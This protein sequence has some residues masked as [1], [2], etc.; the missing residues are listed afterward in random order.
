NNKLDF[1]LNIKDQ[2]AKDKYVIKGVLNQ[3]GLNRY[4]FSLNPDNL[5]LNYDKWTALADNQIQYFNGGINAHNFVLKR[6][7]QELSI[8]SAD[9]SANAP[10][11]INFTNFNISTI[12]AFTHT[13]SLIVNGTLN[14]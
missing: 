4:V 10:L 2:N 1:D 14:G 8:N 3:P 12:T 11:Q 9:T 6:N 13:D 5:L 7:G